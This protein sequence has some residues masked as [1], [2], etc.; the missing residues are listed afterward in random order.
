MQVEW[1]GKRRD[2]RCYLADILVLA[3]ETGR[4]IGAVRQLRVGDLRLGERTAVVP[5]GAI[6]WPAATDKKRKEWSAPISKEVRERLVRLLNERGTLGAGAY[7]FPAPRNANAP[8]DR[9]TLAV[10]LRRAEKAAGVERLAHDAFHGL[11]RKWRSER[12]HLPDADVAE[13]GGWSSIQTMNRAYLQ[14]DRYGVLDAVL[15]PQ[16]LREVQA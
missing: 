11:R 6:C 3:A 10:F 5:Y 14:A 7:L 2:V 1:S 16:R 4:R 15:N 9:E 13:A 12:R 8:G